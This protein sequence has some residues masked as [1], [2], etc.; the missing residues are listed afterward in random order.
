MLCCPAAAAVA[1]PP[2]QTTAQRE[3]DLSAKTGMDDYWAELE[4]AC[5]IWCGPLP[6]RMHAPHC[7]H[8]CIPL[9]AVLLKVVAWI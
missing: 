9:P 5:S 3:H 6:A 8:A 4:A 2:G 1:L 7:A